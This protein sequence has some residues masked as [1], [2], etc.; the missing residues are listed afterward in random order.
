V[1]MVGGTAYGVAVLVCARER[2]WLGRS[3][4]GTLC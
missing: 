1:K 4:L 2:R 3:T